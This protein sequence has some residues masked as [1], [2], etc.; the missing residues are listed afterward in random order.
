MEVV[1]GR[2]QLDAVMAEDLAAEIDGDQLGSSDLVPAETVRIHQKTI[3]SIGNA[4]R[5]VVVD[6]QVPAVV[7]SD[8]KRRRQLHAH[9]RSAGLIS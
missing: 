7:V 2:C 9:V 6:L 4:R 1:A 8:P 5:D 3:G